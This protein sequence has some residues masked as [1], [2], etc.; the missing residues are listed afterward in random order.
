MPSKDPVAEFIRTSFPSVWALELLCFLRQKE[1]QSLSRGEMVAGLRGSE[2][3]ITQSIEALIRA[4]LV[5]ADAD[6][7]AHYAPASPRLAE[8]T[9]QAEARYA[10]SPNAVRRLIVSAVTPSLAAFV[11]AFRLRQER[12]DG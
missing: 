3:V 2:L 8:L 12:D 10:K 4:G 9:A 6:G 7:A 1:G 5:A 11:D